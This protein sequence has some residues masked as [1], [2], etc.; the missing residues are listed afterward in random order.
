MKLSDVIAD[1]R[2]QAKE[3]ER[4][5]KGSALST[6][7]EDA[8]DYRIAEVIRGIIKVLEQVSSI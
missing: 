2:R 4:A 8:G 3:H 7:A 1:L 5:S 6:M